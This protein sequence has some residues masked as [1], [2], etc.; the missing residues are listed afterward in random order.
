MKGI[1]NKLFSLQSEIG[2]ISK[3]QT[4]PFYKS[5]YFDINSLLSQ[6]QPLLKKHKLLLIQP[7]TDNYVRSV[8][9]DVEHKGELM[10]SVESSI[11]LPTD[12][13]AQ[14]IGGAITFYRRYSLT[15]LLALEA[16]DDDGNS[17]VKKQPKKPNLYENVG[18]WNEVVYALED[19]T[20]SL[21]YV[22]SKFNIS[23]VENKLK[24]IIN[25]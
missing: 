16:E 24:S 13:D 15:S 8:L 3:D 22:K 19:G 21:D 18:K 25:K 7:I 5:K 20:V 2:K 10:S 17:T 12:L 6:L 1:Y 14:K 9:V 23:K 4:N 11:E